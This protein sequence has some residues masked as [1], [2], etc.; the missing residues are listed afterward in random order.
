MMEMNSKNAR[1]LARLG[2]R[3]VLGQ[4][5]LDSAADGKSFFAASADLGRTSGFSRFAEIYPQRYINVGIAEQNLIGVAAGLS[6]DGTPVVATS[7]A[8]FASFHCADSVREFLGY[9]RRNIKLI[10]LDSGMA[11]STG[12][13]SHA[14]PQ[15][16]SFMRAIPGLTVLSPCDGVELYLAFKAAMEMDGPVYIRLTG[17]KILPIIHRSGEVQFQIGKGIELQTG[18][19]IA[20]VSCGSILSEA[21]KAAE[22]LE[23][24]GISS[25]VVDMHT[26]KPLDT[27]TLDRLVKYK[28]VVTIEE[29]GVIGGLGGAVAEHLSEK[30]N[31]PPILRLGAADVLPKAGS[32]AFALEQYNL[33]AVQLA[34]SI[35]KKLKVWEE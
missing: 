5:V 31:A 19:D 1:F 11:Q 12:G 9:M 10:G 7:F 3:G 22:V 25:T 8:M 16:I 20:I 2:S 17:D 4:A 24:K 6:A 21:L 27:E 14:N 32:Y 28:L 26:I 29:H 15:D 33:K 13:Y 18:N 23:E 30:R 35:M 34:E